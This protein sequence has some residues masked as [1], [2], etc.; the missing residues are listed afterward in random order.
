MKQKQN[1]ITDAQLLPSAHYHAKPMLGAG[2]SSSDDASD[3]QNTELSAQTKCPQ[4]QNINA[5]ELLK[6]IQNAVP[7]SQRMDFV[8]PFGMYQNAI[9]ALE[10]CEN[11]IRSLQ[12][13]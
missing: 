6:L 10:V 7:Q 1:K 12:Q 2:A 9:N 5:V 4:I 3:G 11:Y 8:V 13:I